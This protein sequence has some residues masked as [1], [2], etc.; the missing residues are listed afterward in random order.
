[1]NKIV[2]VVVTF[3]F[4]S[5]SAQAQTVIQGTVTDVQGKAVEAYV[6]VAPKGVQGIIGFADTDE[7]GRYRVE[8]RTDADSV[9]VTAAGLAIGQQ[10]KVVPN[11]SQTVNFSVSE[12]DVEL[13]EVTVLPE[14]IRQHGDT[15]SYNVGS[16]TQQGDRVIG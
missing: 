8:F 1:M 9:A 11:R 3:A 4:V 10:V 2:F 6:T 16:Y 15:L 12:Q 14:K 13:K 5:F 7:K